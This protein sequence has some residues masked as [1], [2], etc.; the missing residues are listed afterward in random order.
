MAEPR[1]TP[2]RQ[3]ICDRCGQVIR[4]ADDGWLEWLS[5]ANGKA[6]SFKIVH[7][8]QASPR[9]E[10]GCYFHENHPDLM[11]MHLDGFVGEHASVLFS[12]LDVGPMHDKDGKDVPQC[13]NVRE[14]VEL[15]KRLTVPYYEE[16]R[17]YWGVAL[18]DGFFEGA[19]ENWPYLPKNLKLLVKSY[20]EE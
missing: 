1:L 3:W 20:S 9:G 5:D 18:E 12:F 7:H 19:N 11:D 8:A 14:V 17:Q 4:S 13:R 15:M 16:A 10:R 2:L 6:H